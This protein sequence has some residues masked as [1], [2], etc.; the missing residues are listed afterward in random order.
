M[1]DAD[2]D[3]KSAVNFRRISPGGE[4]SR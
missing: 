3:G 1:D 2:R 4:R